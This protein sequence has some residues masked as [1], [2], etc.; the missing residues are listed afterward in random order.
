MVEAGGKIWLTPK[1]KSKYYPRT[2]LR[3]L[4][5]QYY[6]YGFW[7]VRVWQKRRSLPPAR[8]V[9]PLAF[10]L[11]WLLLVVGAALPGL[12]ALEWTLGTFA[13]L[14][15]LG[16]VVGAVDVARHGGVKHALLA[17]L[18]FAV[19]HFAYGIGNLAGVYAFVLRRGKAVHNPT[20][21]QLSR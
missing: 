7:R 10:V 19:L 16:L 6:Q 12:K 9:L 17:P 15:V 1:I 14:Y 5:R 21:Y 8:R 18:V 11:T 20:A 2:S 4:A 3:K 13:G